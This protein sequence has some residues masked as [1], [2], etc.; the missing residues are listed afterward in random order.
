[1]LFGVVSAS[2]DGSV[3][4]D[5]R[6]MGLDLKKIAEDFGEKLKAELGKLDGSRSDAGIRV[7][8]EWV[9]NEERYRAKAY[10]AND[11][12]IATRWDSDDQEAV[13]KV[14]ETASKCR[15][16]SPEEVDAIMKARQ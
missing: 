2:A 15:S 6:I 8:V 10:D 11:V 9:S 14:A 1:M 12:C 3:P 13:R 16:Y 5:W 4:L 7:V